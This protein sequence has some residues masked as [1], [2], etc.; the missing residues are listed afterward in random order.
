MK[1]EFYLGDLRL[2][3]FS[4][5]LP[6]HNIE[7]G[8]I[9]TYVFVNIHISS[10]FIHAERVPF[11]LYLYLY[12]VPL[13]VF[14]LCWMGDNY[15]DREAYNQGLLLLDFRPCCVYIFSI[16]KLKTFFRFASNLGLVSYK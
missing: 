11:D 14:A 2:W 15:H 12:F 16:L 5:S 3:A 4:A 1:V 8:S 6:N 7:P 10:T 9:Y 13:Q